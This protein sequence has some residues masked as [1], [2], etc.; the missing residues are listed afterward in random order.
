MLGTQMDMPLATFDYNELE[1]ILVRDGFTPGTDEFNAEFR[2]RYRATDN[3]SGRYMERQTWMH[4]K[5][6]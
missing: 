4:D 3:H 5:A 1:A 6:A 2:K